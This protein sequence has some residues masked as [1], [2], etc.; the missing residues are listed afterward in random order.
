MCPRSNGTGKVAKEFDVT[1]KEGKFDAYVGD[2]L[3]LK[4]TLHVVRKF[5]L[6]KAL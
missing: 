2:L 4:R 3:L 6:S 1:H 5:L